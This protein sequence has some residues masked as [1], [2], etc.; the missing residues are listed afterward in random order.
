MVEIEANCMISMITKEI[1]P[2]VKSVCSNPQTQNFNL[3]PQTQNPKPEMRN[4]K[5]ETRNSK[6]ETRDPKNPKPKTLMQIGIDS[7]ALAA[8]CAAV[9][10]G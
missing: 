8:A 5:S 10:T 6:H 1:I 4:P 2:A 3:K 9:K 7:K